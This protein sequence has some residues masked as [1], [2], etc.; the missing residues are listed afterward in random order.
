MVH[1]VVLTRFWV[2]VE[3]KLNFIQSTCHT[4]ERHICALND[5]HEFLLTIDR[6]FGLKCCH[7][8]E[9]LESLLQVE[10]LKSQSNVHIVVKSCQV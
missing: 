3:P 8:Y 7:R 5:T 2:C 4:E 9:W 10:V 6:T 1:T